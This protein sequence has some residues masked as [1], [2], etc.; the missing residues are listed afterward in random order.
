MAVFSVLPETLDLIFVSGDELSVELDFGTDLTGYTF[1]TSIVEVLQVSGGAVIDSEEA[2]VNFT[3]T[4]I[5][6][7]EGRINLSL[8]ESQTTSLELNKTYRWWFR[9]VA[10]GIITRTVLSGS[11]TPRTP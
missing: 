8:Q 4:E 9:W 5:D 3:I 7:E 11:V 10:P 6:I 1:A 2:P